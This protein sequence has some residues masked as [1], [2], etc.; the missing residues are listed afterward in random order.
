M[1]PTPQDRTI[2]L[3][4]RLQRI[5]AATVAMTALSQAPAAAVFAVLPAPATSSDVQRMTAL[6]QQAIDRAAQVEAAELAAREAA[7]ASV[8]AT[9]DGL[10]LHLPARNVVV[11]GFHEAREQHLTLLP[12]GRFDLVMPSRGREGTP[13][14]A[15]DIVIAAGE[16]VLA[17]VSGTLRLVSSYDLYEEYTDVLLEIVPDGRP[18]LVVTMYHLDGIQVRTG[19]R[20]EAGQTVLASAARA[21]DFVAQVEAWGRGAH[22]DLRV[23]RA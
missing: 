11:V 18:D 4:T 2:R 21:F 10:D 13:T 16:D 12:Q 7:R 14:S 9:V 6:R 3:S 1:R 5:V 20:V 8:F 15:A 17:P 23:H 22:V 19:Q